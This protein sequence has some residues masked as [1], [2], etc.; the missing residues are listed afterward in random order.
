MEKKQILNCY[1]QSEPNHGMSE[2]LLY[3]AKELK[4]KLPSK[5]KLEDLRAL[6]S[7]HPASKTVSFYTLL[8]RLKLLLCFTIYRL[9]D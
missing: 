3:L 7:D 1:F 8:I 5:I 4:V 6:L 2:G 9:L